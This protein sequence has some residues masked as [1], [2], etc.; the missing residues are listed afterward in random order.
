M[1]I[2]VDLLPPNSTRKAHFKRIYSL[3]PAKDRLKKAI[4]GTMEKKYFG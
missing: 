4:S 3:C 1:A 2:I